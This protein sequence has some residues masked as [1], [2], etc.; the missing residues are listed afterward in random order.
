MSSASE[1]QSPAP[2]I[3]AT[4]IQSMWIGA[5]I[6]NLER[7]GLTSFVANG[8]VVHLYLYDDVAGIPRGVVVRDANEVV[9]QDRIFTT[10]AGS[11]APFSDWFRQEL[12]YQK[13]GYW[14]DLDVICLRPFDFTDDVVVGLEG[15]AITCNAVL[16]FPAGHWLT[17][18]LADLARQPNTVMPY[19]GLG[20]IVRKAARKYLR[21]NRPGDVLWGESA[22]PVG[23][24]RALMH[25]D[26]LGC[27]KPP[28]AFYPI[29]STDWRSIFYR[30]DP[31]ALDALDDSYA[32]HLWNEMGRRTTGFDKNATF[33]PDSLIEQLKR[34]YVGG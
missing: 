28:T 24:T 14:V 9:P 6:S 16:K 3:P 11:V 5:E 27:A 32:V 2:R 34:R 30:N 29:N 31:N 21:G 23:L 20:M 25:H 1:E 22:G 12:L 7:L 33:P 19:D 15:P 18:S 26:L 4:V 17:R 10:R 8:H 13:G